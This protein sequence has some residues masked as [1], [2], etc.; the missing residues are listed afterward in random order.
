MVDQFHARGLMVN[1][2]TVNQ[3][4]IARAMVHAGVDG[5][6]GDDPVMMRET[7]EPPSGVFDLR[8]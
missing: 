4:G 2:W 5:I 8:T 6:I 7:L 1:V 3:A